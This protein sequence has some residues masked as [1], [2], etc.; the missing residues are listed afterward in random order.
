VT[1]GKGV[2]IGQGVRIKHSII[3][4]GTE[5]KDRACIS[6]SILAE[7]CRVG[8]WGRVEGCLDINSPLRVGGITIFGTG[9]EVE[10]EISVRNCIVLPHKSLSSNQSGE[11]IL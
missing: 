10:P 7:N 11:I 1:I 5:I 9:V 2:R 3:L 6:Y 4:E 8:R